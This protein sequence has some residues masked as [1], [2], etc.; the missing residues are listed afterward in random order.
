MKKVIALVAFLSMTML[1]S[2][3]GNG[4]EGV[5]KKFVEL[6][7]QGEFGEAKKYCDEKTG[8]LLGMAESMIPADKKAEAKKQKV[9][10]EI[11]SS[12]IKDDTAKVKYR[13]TVE[14]DKAGSENSGEKTLDLVK[15]DG[16]WKVTIDKENG[17]KEGMGGKGAA[18]SGV[19]PADTMDPAAAPVV[20]ADT[21]Q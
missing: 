3:S 15:V 8:Q 6:T 7:T 16:K 10:V 18:P 12:E 20:P 13:A 14:G 21:L 17:D 19:T 2:C 1:V 11:I 4:P 5:A 9:N